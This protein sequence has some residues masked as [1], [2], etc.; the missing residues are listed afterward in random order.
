M[1]GK[2]SDFLPQIV[3]ILQGHGVENFLVIA[4]DPGSKRE[5]EDEFKAVFG[6]KKDVV[7]A[8]LLEIF[9][10]KENS[11]GFILDAFVSLGHLDRT[12]E[13][14][15]LEVVLEQLKRE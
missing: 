7:V 10:R 5:P 3:E 4:E 14:E 11:L 15:K 6:G 13:G 12:G 8:M 9:R 2:S 1:S